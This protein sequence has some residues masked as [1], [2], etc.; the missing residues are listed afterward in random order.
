MH[1]DHT[2]LLENDHAR[3]GSLPLSV[4]ESDYRETGTSIKAVTVTTSHV[5]RLTKA[6]LEVPHNQDEAVKP[7]PHVLVEK[8]QQELLVRSC[9][10]QTGSI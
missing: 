2:L 4:S 5:S 8:R 3:L 9:E 1:V 10:T 6:P 7:I